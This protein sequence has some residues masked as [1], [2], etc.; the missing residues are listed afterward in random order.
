MNYVKVV[1]IGFAIFVTGIFNPNY[2]R[3]LSMQTFILYEIGKAIRPFIE[4][5]ETAVDRETLQKVYAEYEPMFME[6]V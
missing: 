6:E 1:F 5:N 4:G 3:F 2:V